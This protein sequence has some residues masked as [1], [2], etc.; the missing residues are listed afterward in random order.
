M[1]AARLRRAKGGL[2]TILAIVLGMSASAI[3][4]AHKPPKP[5]TPIMVDR[6]EMRA[7]DKLTVTSTSFQ[8]DAPIP[9][10]Y[11]AYGGGNG[12]SPQIAWSP[13]ASAK[14]YV[15][16][17]E[18]PDAPGPAPYPHWILWNIPASVTALPEGLKGMA[19]YG[20][21]QTSNPHG[22]EGYFGPKPP[23]GD[24]PHH[25]HFEVFALNRM[26]RVASGAGREKIIGAASG[27]V[28]AKGELVATFEAPADAK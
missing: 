28:V 3:T 19:R 1:F 7:D 11:S 26:L 20:L 8:Q 17:V 6:V 21:V 12:L 27:F 4:M 9:L 24:P 15:V 13:Y 18:D 22:S 23:V 14:S 25:Y 2:K 10:Q 5:P 16:V